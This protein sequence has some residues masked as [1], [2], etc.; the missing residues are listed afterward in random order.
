MSN[1]KFFAEIES[2]K[3]ALPGRFVGLCRFTDF[4][5]QNDI[6][7]KVGNGWEWCG[8]PYPRKEIGPNMPHVCEQPPSTVGQ[9]DPSCAKL[10][11]NTEKQGWNQVG[12]LLSI[13]L[14][15]HIMRNMYRIV[16]YVSVCAL[17]VPLLKISL[18]CTPSPLQWGRAQAFFC[19]MACLGAFTHVPI[20]HWLSGFPTG[21]LASRPSRHDMRSAQVDVEA[22]WPLL[23]RDPAAIPVVVV[24][25]CPEM[26]EVRWH[27][28]LDIDGYSDIGYNWLPSDNLTFM[29]ISDMIWCRNTHCIYSIHNILMLYIQ[30]IYIY[31]QTYLDIIICI[32]SLIFRWRRLPHWIW[33]TPM[34]MQF[35]DKIRE[36]LGFLQ[37][38]WGH[39]TRSHP[40]AALCHLG[41]KCLLLVI[42]K[43]LVFNRKP[44]W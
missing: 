22:D 35:A 41:K 13:C 37:W 33:A 20:C 25:E 14:F 16:L 9:W 11:S 34:C 28:F 2:T 4:F 39:F 27:L 18:H 6:K 24:F 3:V 43:P 32:F 26:R 12:D 40:P 8:Y 5:Q 42:K 23:P 15:F 44:H 36:N 1:C 17:H 19:W 29:S 31:V 10:L 21:R 7:H 30:H 38:V